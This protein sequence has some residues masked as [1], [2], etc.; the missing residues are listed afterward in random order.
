MSLSKDRVLLDVT[1]PPDPDLGRSSSNVHT[2]NDGMYQKSS[3]VYVP[4][5]PARLEIYPQ[6]I[7]KDGCKAFAAKITK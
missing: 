5:E 7:I 3:N 2:W 1:C 4:F 6:G